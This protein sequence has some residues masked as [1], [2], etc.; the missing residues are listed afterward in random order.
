M[1][2]PAAGRHAVAMLVNLDSTATSGESKYTFYSE[3]E[4]KQYEGKQ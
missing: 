3:A 1:A 2:T 4:R